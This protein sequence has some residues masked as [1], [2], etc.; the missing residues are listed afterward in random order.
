M[1]K[2]EKLTIS[3]ENMK[4]LETLVMYAED[5]LQFYKQITNYL[6]HLGHK[7][8]DYKKEQIFQEKLHEMSEAINEVFKN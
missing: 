7:L 2:E 8:N 6:Y 4:L 3:K 5:D 1:K